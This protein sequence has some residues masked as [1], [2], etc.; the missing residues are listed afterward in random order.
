MTVLDPD[1][2][3]NAFVEKHILRAMLHYR[4]NPNL[5]RTKISKDMKPQTGAKN[6]TKSWGRG[7]NFKI[8]RSIGF[9]LYMNPNQALCATIAVLLLQIMNIQQQ[10]MFALFILYQRRINKYLNRLS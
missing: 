2:A 8:N 10:Q 3:M 7:T 9:Q 5:A 1:K 6:W 4:Q